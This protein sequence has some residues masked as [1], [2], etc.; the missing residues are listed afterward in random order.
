MTAAAVAALG[1]LVTI[2]GKVP[3]TGTVSGAA[4]IPNGSV[5]GDDTEKRTLTIINKG[6]A[7]I[8]T[9]E[10]A[11]LDFETDNDAVALDEK[12]AVLS[13]VAGALDVTAGDILVLSSADAGETGAADPG[14]L[15]VVTIDKA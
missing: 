11:V 13:E 10:V 1:T 5:T 14:G 3:F 2:L 8:G 9:T 7:G 15:W 12:A 4:F 6:S